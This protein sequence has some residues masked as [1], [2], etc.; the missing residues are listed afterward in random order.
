[1]A[2][3]MDTKIGDLLK[4]P[5]AKAILD[6]YAPGVSNNPMIS[7]AGDLTLNNI[8]SMPQAAQA[9]LNQQKLEAFL[10]EVNQKK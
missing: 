2:Y 5:Q 9:G 3:T 10:Q 6:K 7:M 1:M 4:D 8:L